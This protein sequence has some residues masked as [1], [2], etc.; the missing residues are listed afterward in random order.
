MKIWFRLGRCQH[1]YLLRLL[2]LYI[3][4]AKNQLQ[5]PRIIEKSDE[6]G[7]AAK[8]VKRED[9]IFVILR[10]IRMNGQ[11]DS[12]N[13]QNLHRSLLLECLVP[14][15]LKLQRSQCRTTWRALIFLLTMIS[16]AARAATIAVKP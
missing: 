15:F 13:P 11:R 10:C 7:W 6:K 1:A 2:R 9:S 5:K 16:Y 12:E 3:F 8:K 14:T 4:I